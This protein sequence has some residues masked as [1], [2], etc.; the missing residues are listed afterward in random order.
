MTQAVFHGRLHFRKSLPVAGWNKNRIITKPM[1]ASHLI[2][3]LSWTDPLDRS[4]FTRRIS[5]RNHADEPRTTIRPS[6]PHNAQQFLAQVFRSGRRGKPCRFYPRLSS[7]TINYK[8]RIVRNSN[9][10]FFQSDRS[11]FFN[12]IGFK[13]FSIFLDSRLAT[14]DWRLKNALNFAELVSI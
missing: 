4:N 6:P 8:S 7:K 2:E 10:I 13:S 14:R 9:L 3:N 5:N 11:G 12:C 1:T